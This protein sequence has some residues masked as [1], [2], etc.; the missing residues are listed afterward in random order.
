MLDFG[1]LV[2]VLSLDNDHLI[3]DKLYELV[4]SGLLFSLGLLKASEDLFSKFDEEFRLDQSKNNLDGYQ[5]VVQFET[6]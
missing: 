5:A 2:I 1:L 6:S 4:C 3:I